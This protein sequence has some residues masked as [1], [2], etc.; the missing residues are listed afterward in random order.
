[1][2]VAQMNTTLKSG[3]MPPPGSA[4]PIFHRSRLPARAI[5]TRFV[6]DLHVSANALDAH[7]QRVNG[8]EPRD[9]NREREQRGE[10]D[11]AD[12]K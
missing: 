8:L 6:I 11:V 2:T 9:E 10:R 3:S 7:V 4:G 12:K 5:F 1:M